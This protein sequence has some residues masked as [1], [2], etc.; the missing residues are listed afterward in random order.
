MSSTIGMSRP[1]ADGTAW[2]VS[3]GFAEFNGVESRSIGVS[4]RASF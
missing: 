1:A 2:V 4:Y 3:A